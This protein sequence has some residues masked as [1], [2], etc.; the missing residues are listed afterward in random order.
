MAAYDPLRTRRCVQLSDFAAA[1]SGLL[2]VFELERNEAGKER[3]RIELTDN[4]L[5]IGE[6]PREWMQRHNVAV[7][8]RGQGHEIMFPATARLS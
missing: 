7:A 6:T 5:D 1:T 8:N 2:P 4:R 3:C